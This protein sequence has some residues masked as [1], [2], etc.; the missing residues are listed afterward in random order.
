MWRH[1]V[2]TVGVYSAIYVRDIILLSVIPSL[3][4]RDGYLAAGA[5]VSKQ[6]G[7][8]VKGIRGSDATERHS[9]DGTQQSSGT[10]CHHLA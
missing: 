2:R 4:D 5:D 3:Q 8:Q 1:C 6:K 10:S 7:L 9:S